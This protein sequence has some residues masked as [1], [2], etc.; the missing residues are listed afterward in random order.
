MKLLQIIFIITIYINLHI[1]VLAENLESVEDSE[2]DVFIPLDKNHPILNQK[3]NIY[4]A[5]FKNYTNGK[6]IAL[7]KI[8]ATS[9][10]IGLKAGE[11]KYFG[12]IKIKLHKC[13]KNLD[14]YNQDNYLLM[15]ITEYKIDEDPTL[16]FQGWMVSSS[17]SL[18]TFEHPIYEIFA[19]DCF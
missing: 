13:I 1:F 3:D 2:N 18:S 15:T 10:E 4:S 5:E 11:E 17:I 9:E 16:L 14:P 12:N 7:N 6:I 8:T 19:K